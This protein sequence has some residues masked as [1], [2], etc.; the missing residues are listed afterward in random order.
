MSRSLRLTG[1]KG[2]T[3]I[4]QLSSLRLDSFSVDD[5]LVDAELLRYSYDLEVV[6]SIGDREHRI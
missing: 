6:P 5:S 2:M 3:K 4:P 1:E